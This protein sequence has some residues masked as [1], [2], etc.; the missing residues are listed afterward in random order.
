MPL[1]ELQTWCST[2]LPL[3]ATTPLLLISVWAVFAVTPR[4]Q[5]KRS[6]RKLDFMAK[7]KIV[8]GI[9][10]PKR[11]APVSKLIENVMLANFYATFTQEL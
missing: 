5:P 7:K 9:Q 11:S 4:K 3:S 1:S 2:I 6:K 8:Y 10:A